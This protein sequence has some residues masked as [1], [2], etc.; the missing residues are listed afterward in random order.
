MQE[1]KQSESQRYAFILILSTI[2]AYAIVMV[3][4]KIVNLLHER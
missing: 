1:S 3:H 4:Q 2:Y